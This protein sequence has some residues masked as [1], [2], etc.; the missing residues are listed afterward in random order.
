MIETIPVPAQDIEWETSHARAEG[1][2]D[3]ADR[4]TDVHGAL[5]WPVAGAIVLSAFEPMR[6]AADD[7]AT[8]GTTIEMGLDKADGTCGKHGTTID[9]QPTRP[10]S[11]EK[12]E[13]TDKKVHNANNIG[14]IGRELFEGNFVR[15][16][17]I[18][19]NAGAVV[20]RDALYKRERV[21]S[22]GDKP[23]MNRAKTG[24]QKLTTVSMASRIDRTPTGRAI[25]DLA[26]LAGTALSIASYARF[27]MK[28]PKIALVYSREEPALEVQPYDAAST[29]RA[30]RLT[31][32]LHS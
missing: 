24:V 26:I 32:V 23:F 4:L 15:A 3:F 17:F 8:L 21:P 22:S 12:D 7:V 18:A 1:W 16:S 20:I 9:G 31:P 5:A 19:A 25:N 13:E 10:L 14:F 11:G 30:A 27:K 28:Q 6:A 2:R 29:S